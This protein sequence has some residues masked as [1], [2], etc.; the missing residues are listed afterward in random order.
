MD[1][2][3]IFSRLLV[4]EDLGEREFKEIAELSSKYIE[5]H[6][7]TGD[8]YIKNRD[9]YTISQRLEILL[10]GLWISQE[11]KLLDSLAVT[12]ADLAEKLGEKQTSVSGPLSKLVKSNIVTKKD[13]AYSLNPFR[14]KSL[15]KNLESPN[16]SSS[17]DR[18]HKKN[19]TPSLKPKVPKKRVYKSK[20][21]KIDKEKLGEEIIQNELKKYNLSEADL[22]RI[23]NI[24]NNNI[25]LLK[26]PENTNI[27]VTH[28][29]SSL[30]LLT[31]NKIYFGDNEIES[32]VLRR[33]LENAGITG[34]TNLSTALKGFSECII[35]KRG[36]KGNT[37]TNYKLTN[38]GY[39]YGIKL[40][41]D[42]IF[43]TNEFNLL[44]KKGSRKRIKKPTQEFLINLD[45]DKLN[46]NTDYF[47]RINSIEKEKLLSKFELK[48]DGVR[49]LFR[50]DK[51]ARKHKQ[52]DTLL[53]LG[54]I[55][56]EI[57]KISKF[58]CAVLLKNSHQPHERLDLLPRNP[59]FRK[60]FAANNNVR[61]MELNYNGLQLGK[62]MILEVC[63]IEIKEVY[64]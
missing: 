54:V 47:C 34:L 11:L 41:K 63:E 61:D 14:V 49:I 24:D 33:Q 3:K 48:N 4:D 29:K 59:T 5:I 22:E 40:I 57:Y 58:D 31:A 64:K 36:A 18:A 55:L 7:C 30:L 25:I 51:S 6:K 53:Y 38:Y 10:V 50:I 12:C 60:C 46:D 9:S 39:N 37:L 62:K 43:G 8:I 16:I 17:L 13:Q 20:Q 45:E 44:A 56:K 15:L 35:H 19:R 42:M 28:L 52:I 21:I 1:K 2:S 27:R 32:S 26:K 23:F